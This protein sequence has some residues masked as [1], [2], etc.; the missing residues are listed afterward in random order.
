MD[1]Q[2]SSAAA[3]GQH[4]PMNGNDELAKALG[5]GLQFEETPLGSDAGG[6]P[7]PSL[8]PSPQMGDP[9]AGIPLPPLP[10]LDDAKPADKDDVALTP[11][12]ELPS[13]HHAHEKGEHMDG[14]KEDAPKPH[15]QPKHDNAPKDDAPALNLS[16]DLGTKPSTGDPALDKI[17][18][19]ALEELKPLVGKLNLNPEEKFDTLLLIIRSTDDQSLLD[20]AHD[21]A[22]NISDETKRAQALLDII[23]EVDYFSTKR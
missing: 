3:D 12:P 9:L 6:D 16:D 22:K 17:K 8:T 20:E 15:D 19:S 5:G 23:K 1:Q 10:P 4:P 11:D 21:A 14:K 7:A 18:N 2:D 13:V